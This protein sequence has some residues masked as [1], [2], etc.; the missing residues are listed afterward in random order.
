MDMNSVSA[1]YSDKARFERVRCRAENL[2]VFDINFSG[3]ASTDSLVCY[4]RT[5]DI[6]E[7]NSELFDRNA[8][9]VDN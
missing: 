3:L 5:L 9:E 1:G 8:G 7:K 4:E 6:I 2:G